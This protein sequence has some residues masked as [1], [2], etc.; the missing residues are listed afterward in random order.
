VIIIAIPLLNMESIIP[1]HGLLGSA[2][3]IN[4]F[5]NEKTPLREGE[6]LK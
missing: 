5:W 3:G 2:S 4:S 6:N 1:V